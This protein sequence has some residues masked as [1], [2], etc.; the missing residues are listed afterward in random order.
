MKVAEERIY[1]GHVVAATELNPT[2]S[3]VLGCSV[4]P[5]AVKDEVMCRTFGLK[6]NKVVNRPPGA[7]SNLEA[8][9][10]IMVGPGS[11]HNGAGSALTRKFQLGQDVF[12]G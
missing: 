10:A 6:Q 11:E 7:A 9:E 3:L 8:N 2:G 5:H 1:D 12:C 4:N